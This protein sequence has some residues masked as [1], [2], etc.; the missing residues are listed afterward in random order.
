MRAAVR[1]VVAWSLAAV[2]ACGGHPQ[3]GP[4]LHEGASAPLV[5]PAAAPSPPPAVWVEAY[6]NG[7]SSVALP[8][9]EID[10]SA[11]THLMMFALLPTASGGIDATT[12]MLDPAAIASVAAAAHA[13]GKKVLVTIG[14][15]SSHDLFAAAISDA[16]RAAFVSAVVAYAAAN[17]YDGVDVDMEPLG[18]A[19][20]VTYEAFVKQLRAALPPGALLT[21]ATISEPA[22]FASIQS[23][24]DRVDLM[25]YHFVP[26]TPSFVWHN[27]ALTSG[28]AVEPSNGQPLPSCDAS[29]ARFVNAGVAREKLGIGIDFNGELWAG[30]SA[31]G[32]TSP[33]VTSTP[34]TYAQIMDDYF[35]E[36]HYAWDAFASAPSLSIASPAFI[37]YD[38]PTLIADKLDYART[39]GLGSVI[40]WSLQAGYRAS[41]PAGARDA[42]LQAVKGAAGGT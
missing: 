1:P 23:E 15:A 19:D 18:S 32:T 42:L 13:A 14:G 28:G 26:Q 9:T 33:A 36:G 12:K 16:N 39:R 2:F 4:S 10:F 17:A 7:V 11:F 34:V 27:A 25:T 30:A 5:A 31:L 35:A 22:L 29:L 24:L 20:E 6:Y 41:Q 40:V 3:V 8:A 38:D 21:A 37:T